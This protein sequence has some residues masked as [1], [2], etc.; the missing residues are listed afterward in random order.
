MRP[1]SMWLQ[2]FTGLIGLDHS[3]GSYS[4]DTTYVRRF[5]TLN[6]VC[7]GNKKWNSRSIMIQSSQSGGRKTAKRCRSG[8]AEWKNMKLP[9]AYPKHP[10]S[11]FLLLFNEFLVLN[12][13][14][15]G[16][17]GTA[18]SGR[19]DSK[20]VGTLGWWRKIRWET[21][22][23]RQSIPSWALR[24]RSWG[25]QPSRMNKVE[26][27]HSEHHHHPIKNH[28]VD[29]VGDQK[30]RPTLSQLNNT[31]DTPD[32]DASQREEHGV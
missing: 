16:S 24:T 21:Y 11:S 6:T 5:H 12:C 26:D 18:G 8:K 15:P 22:P 27:S 29:L 23:R 9:C 13:P 2:W 17:T 3:I 10:M 25:E 31:I 30:T 1:I 7:R 28:K 19:Q 20:S 32:V 4:V 14:E